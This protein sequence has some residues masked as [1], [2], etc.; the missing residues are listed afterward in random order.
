MIRSTYGRAAIAAALLTLVT[1]CAPQVRAPSFAPAELVES[2]EAAEAVL[3]AERAR[4]TRGPVR[5]AHV[6]EMVRLGMWEEADALL[7]R[8]SRPDAELRMAEAELRFRQHR[9]AAADEQVRA[10]L[11]ANPRHRGA[12]LLHARL[13]VQAWDLPAAEGTVRALL[14]VDAR[15]EDAHLLIGR[16]RLLQR[17]YGEALQIARQVQALNPGNAAAHLLEADTRFW[18]QDPAGAEPS[19][20]RAL[21]LDPFDADARFN[22]GYA[23]WRRVDATQLDAM[24]AQWRLALEVDPL[25][26][27]THWHWGNGHTNLTYAD[28][29]EPSDTTVRE[30]LAPAEAMISSGDIHGAL[31]WA[32]GVRGEFPESVLPDM[33][34]ASAFYMAYEMERGVRLDSAETIFRGILE[35]KRNYGPAHNGLAAVIK[36]RQ[37]EVLAS[38][39]SLN[40]EIERT[41]LPPNPALAAVIPDVRYYPGDRVEKMVR[42]QLGPSAAYLPMI[43]RQ[44]RQYR[45]PPLHRDLAQT[46]GQAFFRTATT[47][48][49]RQW[50]D[51]RGVG[52][53]AAGIE[54]LERGS[55][56]ERDVFLHEFVHLFHNIVFTDRESAARAAALP[57]C[58]GGRAH[59]RLLR[60]QQRARVPRPGVPG[61]PLAGEDPSA[62]PQGDGDARPAAGAGPADLRLHRLAGDATARVPG[63]R[64]LARCGA[65]G[66]RCT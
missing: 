16:I 59:A 26:Y 23:I 38:F 44:E 40:T 45:L 9:Y 27:V 7:A 25:H 41:P 13:Q 8:V 58:G 43:Q 28:Y 20:V 32:R 53:G 49:N 19:L 22:Y 57:R 34:R 66:R 42:Q 18:D 31:Q 61:L 48:D 30:R 1:A 15:D 56:Q 24:A 29:A 36:Q 50:M 60:G 11:A 55:Y 52:S 12:R 21:T 65:T 17:E 5:G 2:V 51:I 3:S 4:L 10:V 63:R 14:A 47:F 33:L 64:P 6:R 35:R 39:D 37:F 62:E 46:M 54:Y